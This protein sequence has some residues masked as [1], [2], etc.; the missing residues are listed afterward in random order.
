MP[1]LKPT[2]PRKTKNTWTPKG[3]S[4]RRGRPKRTWRDTFADDMR[5]MGVSGSGTYDE[6]RSVASDRARWR[7]LV[8][9]CSR[10]DR[11]T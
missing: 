10:R 4:R 7:Q 2:C 11:R 1:K 8:A 6:A 9:Q 3:G 5:E